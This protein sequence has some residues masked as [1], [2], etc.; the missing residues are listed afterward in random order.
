MKVTIYFP[1]GT[2]QVF[3]KGVS[4]VTDLIVKGEGT[5]LIVKYKDSADKDAEYCNFPMTVSNA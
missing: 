1:D 2:N 4:G 5:K 3:E